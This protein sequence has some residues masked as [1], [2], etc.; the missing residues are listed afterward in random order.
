MNAE[1]FAPGLLAAI[2]L[3][4]LLG[5]RHGFDADHI[6]VVDGMT[7]ARQ[8][9]G[10]YGAARLLGLQFA[11]GHSATIL[12]AASLLFG[13]GTVLPQWLDGVG[14]VISTALLLVTPVSNAAHALSSGGAMAPPPG[15]VAAL[16]FHLTGR[17]LHLAL[18]GVGLVG[19]TRA[20]Y[21]LRIA[22]Q[23]LR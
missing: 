3:A 22:V 11:A 14:I 20:V 7:R 4:G 21:T 12:V 6:A 8:L 13:Q 19:F 5:F 2:S 15:P 16:W 18:V 23:R 17:L 10:R 9:H 1:T